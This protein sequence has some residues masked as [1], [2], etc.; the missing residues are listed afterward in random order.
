M[1]NNQFVSSTAENESTTFVTIPID[2]IKDGD[3]QNYQELLFGQLP[4]G[5][6]CLLNNNGDVC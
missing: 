1:T 6:Y 4:D 2:L 5:T 3:Q